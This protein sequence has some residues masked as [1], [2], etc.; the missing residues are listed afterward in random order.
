MGKEKIIKIGMIDDHDLLRKG[1][2][3]FIRDDDN[4]EIVFEAENGKLA[5]KK[6]EQIEVIPDIMVVDINMPVMN[7]FETAKA[8]LEKYPQTKILAFSIN[9]DVQDVVK[10]LNSGAKG[11]ILKGADPEELKK[12]I[13]V[14]NDGGRYFSAGVA[15]VAKEYYKQFP[16]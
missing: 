13:T 14:L 15:E 8:L 3:D 6:M 5:L 7:G 16:Q 12:A 10:M 4:F 11:Y 1:I 2:C 9:D